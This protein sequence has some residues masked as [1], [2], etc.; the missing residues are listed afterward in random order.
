[1]EGTNEWDGEEE[2]NI[3]AAAAYKNPNN[4]P[5][6]RMSLS[7]CAIICWR[8]PLFYF[9][10]F[11]S[12]FHDINFQ[13]S[14]NDC[15]CVWVSV[16]SSDCSSSSHSFLSTIFFSDVLTALRTQF[17]LTF[18]LLVHDWQKQTIHWFQFYCYDIYFV[19]FIT[20]CVFAYR[21]WSWCPRIEAKIR[22]KKQ[23]VAISIF[24]LCVAPPQQF[25]RIWLHD[26]NSVS[27]KVNKQCLSQNSL[28]RKPIDS[29][30]EHNKNN[31]IRN[32][33]CFWADKFSSEIWNCSKALENFYNK[34]R[35]HTNRQWKE[36][37]RLQIDGMQM[38]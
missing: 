17:R 10:L 5:N 19:T 30:R 4:Q 35:M 7:V 11:C 12:V 6:A 16:F 23:Y 1:M 26:Y 9:A 22:T 37:I 3:A 20:L 34:F 13:L 27:R 32:C 29:S 2:K 36:I 8:L 14:L 15:V 28:K 18:C 33:L 38:S 31:T 25:K 24:R 21:T